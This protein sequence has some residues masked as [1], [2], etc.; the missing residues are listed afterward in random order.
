MKSF[1]IKRSTWLRAEGNERSFLLRESDKKMC[2][3]GQMCVSAGVRN[4]AGQ[5]E[6]K[7]NPLLPSFL[8][9]GYGNPSHECYNL[10][11]IN[12]FMYEGENIIFDN[13]RE[14]KIIKIFA[15]HKIKVKFVD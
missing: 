1:T 4:I 11:T 13:E 8:F 10:M 9:D 3:L 14:R 12:D 7:L 2:C 15:K 6:P 5:R